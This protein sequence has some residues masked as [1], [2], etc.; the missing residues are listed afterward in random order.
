LDYRDGLFWG[1]TSLVD[2]F[3]GTFE[4]VLLGFFPA[5]IYL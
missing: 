2:R 3:A 4:E 5:F 1:L